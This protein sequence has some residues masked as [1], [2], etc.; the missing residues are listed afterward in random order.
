MLQSLRLDWRWLAAAATLLLLAVLLSI[1]QAVTA[2]YQHVVDALHERGVFT[3]SR[4]VALDGALGE[5]IVVPRT[6]DFSTVRKVLADAADTSAV[7]SVRRS[8]AHVALPDGSVERV[9]LL[10]VSRR[11]GEFLSR[12]SE[13]NPDI[14]YWVG[15]APPVGIVR[16]GDLGLLVRPAPQ[17]ALIRELAGTDATPVLLVCTGGEWFDSTEVVVVPALADSGATFRRV[18]ERLQDLALADSVFG[19]SLFEAETLS[20]RLARHLEGRL[21]W[22]ERLRPMVASLKVG[23]LFAFGIFLAATSLREMEIQRA[24][25]ASLGFIGFRYLRRAASALLPALLGLVAVA[26]WIGW[27]TTLQSAALALAYALLLFVAGLAAFLLGFFVVGL[28]RIDSR[29][30][31]RTTA[32]QGI[33]NARLAGASLAGMIALIGPFSSF[34][35][36]AT[37][38]LRAL[39]GLDLGYQADQLWVVRAA[40]T[41]GATGLPGHARSVAERLERAAS[42]AA[43]ICSEPWMDGRMPAA[44]G[45]SGT[46]F[47]AT[48]GIA[49]VLGLRLDGRDFSLADMGNARV[50]LVQA[51]VP[52]NRRVA[53]MISDPVGL[54]SGF[55]VGASAPELRFVMFRALDTGGCQGSTASIVFRSSGALGSRDQALRIGDSLREYRLSRPLRVVDVIDAQRRN[56]LLLRDAAL[57][58]LLVGMTVLGVAS[59]MIATAY[60]RFAR[61]VLAIRLAI[62]ERPR[63]AAWRMAGQSLVW[64]GT[65]SLLGVLLALAARSG[66]EAALPRADTQAFA[67]ALLVLPLVALAAFLGVFAS[68]L[69]MVGRL[70]LA[71]LLRED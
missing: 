36:L 42:G 19:R 7:G 70:P 58:L 45:A 13:C 32:T 52:A 55:R 68:C 67:E 18:Q 56:L 51:L 62:G 65:G 11:L 5:R 21:A 35:W 20:A 27:S 26:C 43:M 41:A 66:I 63:A 30:A 14:G 47:L 3:L 4:S 23:V 33:W 71:S 12:S 59:V 57:A 10:E 38:E 44:E 54:F 50:S 31:L 34:A 49:Q 24:L 48:A 25:G 61:R 6:L 29:L 37:A 46:M 64:I 39:R 9:A 28:W 16:H 15:N 1:A 17:A 53:E 8:A 69:W 2:R 22:I 40:P 60:A